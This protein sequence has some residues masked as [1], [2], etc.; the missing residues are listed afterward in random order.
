MTF[1]YAGL[2]QKTKDLI[3]K[4]GRSVTLRRRVNSG[5]AYNPT[6]TPTD[7]A[8]TVVA[9]KYN[10]FEVDGALILKTDKKFIMSSTVVPASDDLIVDGDATYSIINIEVVGPG[11]TVVLYK[12]QG[13]I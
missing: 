11:D 3:T 10:S 9:T 7:I 1:S 2:N 5:T 4:F 6:V 12:I 8:A 13:R